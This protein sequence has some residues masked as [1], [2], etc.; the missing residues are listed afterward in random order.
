MSVYGFT[1][2]Q[3]K[4]LDWWPSDLTALI[5]AGVTGHEHEITVTLSPYDHREM[6]PRFLVEVFEAELP[7]LW[8][9]ENR[10]TRIEVHPSGRL[11]GGWAPEDVEQVAKTLQEMFDHV[12][13][14]VRI[15]WPDA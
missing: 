10:G 6:I 14:V 5:Q 11:F 7:V 9:V 1:L 13:T 4:A 3:I 8:K 12:E 2:D 15:Q